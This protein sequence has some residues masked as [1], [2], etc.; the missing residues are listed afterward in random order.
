MPQNENEAFKEAEKVNEFF[1]DPRQKLSKLEKN[2]SNTKEKTKET[3][4]KFLPEPMKPLMEGDTGDI[5]LLI[6]ALLVIGIFMKIIGFAFRII[7]KLVFIAS[8]I[9]ALY[10]IFQKFS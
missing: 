4:K 6:I 8:I 9:A 2:F 3:I 1:T 5:V 7:I 10:I